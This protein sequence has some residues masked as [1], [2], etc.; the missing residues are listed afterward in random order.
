MTEGQRRG[1]RPRTPPG[2]EYRWIDNWGWALFS[3]STPIGAKAEAEEALEEAQETVQAVEEAANA[4]GDDDDDEAANEDA[5][6]EDRAEDVED[7]VAEALEEA[8]EH[9]RATE[10][11]VEEAEAA[12]EADDDETEAAELAPVED[13]FA[14]AR[15]ARL[16]AQ[17]AKNARALVDYLR[18]EMGAG[19]VAYLIRG[20]LRSLYVPAVGVR[21]RF[22]LNADATRRWDKRRALEIRLL[23]SADASASALERDEDDRG[24]TR[25][26]QDVAHDDYSADS[27]PR[28]ATRSSA[29][30]QWKVRE[31]KRFE[32]AGPL[33]KAEFKLKVVS[34]R[35][36]QQRTQATALLAQAKA[37]TA[38][39]KLPKPTKI[40]L[41]PT[42]DTPW[43]GAETIVVGTLRPAPRPRGR[44][45]KFGRIMSD[46]ERQRRSRS[47]LQLVFPVELR[48]IGIAARSPK[49]ARGGD[50]NCSI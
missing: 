17:R 29:L 10:E 41:M 1:K 45:S 49:I 26:T 19:Y 23:Q 7:T 42:W 48:A 13:L 33:L 27:S 18:S 9:L 4:D 37:Q 22:G 40:V 16:A 25:Y 12:A 15:R 28:R 20:I 46:A 8:L 21:S 47:G 30:K 3:K 38:G 34:S 11:S 36:A 14:R 6:E 5:D 43:I 44:P 31:E 24:L 50:Q 2:C 39:R 35:R 32:A